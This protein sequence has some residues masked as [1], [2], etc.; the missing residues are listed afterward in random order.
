MSSSLVMYTTEGGTGGMWSEASLALIISLCVLVV[1][2][3][4]EGSLY[5]NKALSTRY[6]N[7]THR[8]IRAQS[9]QYLCEFLT[10][11]NPFTSHT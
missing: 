6:T 1:V 7:T 8:S 5:I 3:G 11:L 10:K 4:G 2:V 9:S